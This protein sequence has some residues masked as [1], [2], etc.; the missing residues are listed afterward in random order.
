MLLNNS[1]ISAK[2]LS[3]DNSRTFLVAL[4]SNCLTNIYSSMA[5]SNASL[6]GL[7]AQSNCLSDSI[8]FL[9]QYCL[10]LSASTLKP[11]NINKLHILFY[12]W[13]DHL[14]YGYVHEPVNVHV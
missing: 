9:L 1:W 12:I 6:S 5:K 8:N 7:L 14:L 10:G 4:V 11:L 3:L 13:F 2:S